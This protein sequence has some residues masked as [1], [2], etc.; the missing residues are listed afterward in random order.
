ML[1]CRSFFGVLVE[2][3]LICPGYQ[4]KGERRI[5]LTRNLSYHS[6]ADE[7]CK[8]TIEECIVALL[9]TSRPPIR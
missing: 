8:T 9:D 5:D 3:L 7:E 4:I 6:G 2:H 1:Y